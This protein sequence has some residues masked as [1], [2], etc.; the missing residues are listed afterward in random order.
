MITDFIKEELQKENL[1]YV[2]LLALIVAV[3]NYQFLSQFKQLPSPLYG[4][5]YYNHLGTMYHI[6]YGGSILESGQ[7][8][9]E[10]PWV[11]W[12][13]HLYVV[14]LSKITGIDPLFGIIYSS[15]PLIFVS[16]LIVYVLISKFT[17]DTLLILP[18]VLIFLTA[19]PIY[20][21]T[22]FGFYV[23][24]PLMILAWALFLE[25][26]TK[27][28]MIF[29]AVASALASLSSTQLFFAQIILLGVIGI[30]RFYQEYKKTKNLNV[31]FS[32]EFATDML[33]LVKAFAI[34]FVISL[35]YWYWPLFVYKG[36]TPNDIQVYGWPDYTK[37]DL[38]IQTI[39][40][41]LGDEFFATNTDSLVNTIY[42]VLTILQL[43][44]VIALFKR[45]NESF[46]HKT[47][48]LVLISAFVGLTHHL[49]MF[50]LL[51]SHLSPGH[52][53]QMLYY[54]I[55]PVIFVVGIQFLK[56]K[57][58]VGSK[59]NGKF[60]EVVLIILAVG[61]LFSHFS[62]FEAKK[63]GNYVAAGREDLSVLHKDIQSWV[64]ANTSIND[65]FLTNNE[66]GFMLNALTGRKLVTLRR[67]HAPVYTD[68]DKRMLDT[69]VMLYGNNDAL[70]KELLKK[71]NVKYLFWSVR[72]FQNEFQID[73]SGHLTGVFDPLMVKD[74]PEYRKYLEQNGIQ[75]TTR[76]GS[77]DPFTLP[78]Y[79]TY[80]LLVVIPAKLEISHPWSDA[81]D[82][83]ITPVKPIGV[84]E[85]D[86]LQ[87]FAL[88]YQVKVS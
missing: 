1:K 17:D 12:L 61:F 27:N 3:V 74:K 14:I 20:K 82:K 35:I 44:G 11:P 58:S 80:D 67:T 62:N 69:A 57:I 10:I 38:Q 68:M 39:T 76:H 19:Y 41:E 65:V 66:D 75:Y 72:W 33:P 71:Y 45:R 73:E 28:R 37:F 16:A 83:Y 23:T 52:L 8:T 53:F 85:G 49:V 32:K 30:D 79:P 31:I 60:F 78:E 29:A 48:F 63:D 21:Y 84:K 5:D 51:K 13:Y 81:L 22:L 59:G 77:L 18:V 36:A 2:L 55:A 64:D 34:G 25:K 9:G 56:T 43:I 40:K 88:I 86:Q 4:G 6:F 24:S 26:Q 87:L 70:R 47:A 42:S 7:L 46:W 54:P 50:N 15:L